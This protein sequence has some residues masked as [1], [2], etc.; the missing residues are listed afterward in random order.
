MTASSM[1]AP[2]IGLPQVKWQPP[3][4]EPDHSR[5]VDPVARDVDAD[6]LL[7]DLVVFG[8]SEIGSKR[9]NELA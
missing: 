4:V 6:F 7:Q 2:L 9:L 5:M 8:F 1:E 3:A